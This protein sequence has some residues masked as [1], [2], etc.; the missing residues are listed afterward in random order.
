MLKEEELNSKILQELKDYG[1]G[2]R[3]QKVLNWF[4]KVFLILFRGKKNKFKRSLP[5]GDYF[6]DRWEKAKALSF[7]E[8]TSVYDNVLVLGNVKVGKNCWIGP[9]VVLDGSGELEIG[10]Y[11]SI[12]AGVQ[13]YSHDSI[14]WAISGGKEDYEYAKTI[15]GN[16]VYIGPN[17]I[18]QKGVKIGDKV[19][20]GA[21]SFVNCDIPSN[22]KAYGSPVKIKE[23]NV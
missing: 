11:C 18:I 7:G 20:I 19:V 12:S 13:I 2:I 14:K 8:G 10:D 3:E 5:F 9:N 16:N 22:S 17:V 21:N 23:M 1:G 6:V 15:I 4:L